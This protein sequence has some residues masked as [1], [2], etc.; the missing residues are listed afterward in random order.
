MWKIRIF[1]AIHRN[2]QNNFRFVAILIKI[3]WH[4]E[5]A[6]RTSRF[7]N[8]TTSTVPEDISSSLSSSKKIYWIVT[9]LSFRSR[10][11]NWLRAS[12]C[13]RRAI[14]I[15]M[16]TKTYLKSVD[17]PLKKAIDKM[18]KYG[19]NFYFS[20]KSLVCCW[21]YAWMTVI[22]KRTSSSHFEVGTYIPF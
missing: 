2:V 11:S 7:I 10:H 17:R 8:G 15:R 4:I 22:N 14:G 20:N 9:L 19:I 3:D 18:D 12:N 5:L 21:W 6:H 16:K 13:N 1:V